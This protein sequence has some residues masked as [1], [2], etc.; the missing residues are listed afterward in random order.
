VDEDGTTQQRR[1]SSTPALAA[2]G[3]TVVAVVAALV[4]PAFLSG[5][6][7][8]GPSVPRPP[9]PTREADNPGSTTWHAVRCQ[10]FE[11]HGCE[12][13]KEIDHGGALFHTVGGSQ[14]TVLQDS[15]SSRRLSVTVPGSRHDRWVLVGAV[16]AGQDSSL[17]VVIGSAVEVAVGSGRLTLF[18]LS[19]HD[20][21]VVTVSDLGF[22]R[23]G[24]VLHV[25]Q[26]EPR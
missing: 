15:P 10:P 12:D 4:T 17:N 1:R 9:A 11:V 7:A 2:I 3:A 20:R 23:Q 21:T 18:A 16:G 19:G 8:G 25:Q 24:E 5:S 14:Q 22:P 26:Y 6:G 13:P